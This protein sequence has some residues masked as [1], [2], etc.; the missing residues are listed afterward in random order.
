[1]MVAAGEREHGVCE[2][3]LALFGT[4]RRIIRPV[5]RAVKQAAIFVLSATTLRD[6]KRESPRRKPGQGEGDFLREIR[7]PFFD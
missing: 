6:I 7:A 4:L 2:G 3:F 1:M 5:E